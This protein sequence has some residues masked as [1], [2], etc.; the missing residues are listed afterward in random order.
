MPGPALD[1]VAAGVLVGAEVGRLNVAVALGAGGSVSCGASVGIAV[2]WLVGPGVSVRIRGGGEVKVTLGSMVGL[3]SAVI[4]K[5]GVGKTKGVGAEIPGTL[6]AS[7]TASSKIK[8]LKGFNERR[9]IS[10]PKE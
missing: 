7:V 3:K 6:Q 1:L 4:V 9:D 10:P 8:G 2:S 5:S